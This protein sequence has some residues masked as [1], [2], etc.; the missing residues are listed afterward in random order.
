MT[1][2]TP[3][4]PTATNGTSLSRQ[5]IDE[6]SETLKQLLADVFTL[7]MKTK[8]FHWHITGRHFRDYHLLLDE[9]AEQIFV[10]TD[11]IAE[12]ARKIGGYTLRSVGTF[13]VINGSKTVRT[14]VSFHGRCFPNFGTIMPSWRAPF[15][16]L[17][18]G[19]VRTRLNTIGGR[20]R[21]RGRTGLRPGALLAIVLISPLAVFAVRQ[22]WAPGSRLRAAGSPRLH[23]GSPESA[24]RSLSSQVILAF[25]L[26][27]A[28][29]SLRSLVLSPSS[30]PPRRR[31][32]SQSAP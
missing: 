21:C 1:A 25:T 26:C 19:L 9:H 15:D 13:P 5:A 31:G 7:Y 16:R 29:S 22:L 28:A 18:L 6:I 10:M 8:G 4:L 12:R 27:Q 3:K 24:V 32:R 2:K 17:A 30:R 23:A 14:E 20:L 11:D